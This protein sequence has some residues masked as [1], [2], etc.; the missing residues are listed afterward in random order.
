[1]NNR[2]TSSGETYA[3]DLTW[4]EQDILILLSERLTNHEIAERL[5][6][7]ESTVKDYVGRIISKLYAKNR[8]DAVERAKVLGL[9]DHDQE[10]VVRPTVNLPPERTPFVGRR[11]ELAEI[12]QCLQQTRLL[13]LTGPGGIGKT[14][15]A[16]KV[17]QRVAD[18]FADGCFFVSLAPIRSVSHI[19]QTIAEAVKFPIAT[20]DDPRHQ[21]LRYLKNRKLLLVIDN[22]EH[23]MDGVDIV[24]EIIQT[25]PDVK[26]LV[27][28]RERLNLQSEMNFI[29]GGLEI[30]SQEKSGEVL[31]NDAVALFIQSACKVRPG[32]D[33]S[34]GEL[35][36]ITD[37]CQFV[38]GMPL[39][40]E[41]AAA[42]LYIL[43]LDEVADEL[44]KGLD[45]LVNRFGE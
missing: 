1:M 41:L 44:K 7:A 31:N 15:L 28:S 34:P 39:A 45:I 42:W 32:F 9:L 3:D 43:N 36:K 20:H 17:A 21:L 14:R 19:V 12:N 37:I 24:S 33:P 26:I 18:D 27:T 2:G 30:S 22:F 8:R 11:S 5:H 4:R 25:A 13:T 6:L 35:K 38:Q 16:L 23:M 40:I 10:T 29:V